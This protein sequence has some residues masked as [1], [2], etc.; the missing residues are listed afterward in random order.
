MA[1]PTSAAKK[2]SIAISAQLAAR[3]AKT[4]RLNWCASGNPRAYQRNEIQIAAI[5]A[6]ASSES[7]NRYR[8]VQ[9]ANLADSS[10]FPD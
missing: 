2:V 3:F 4:S 7:R 5:I 6:D 8:T 9:A 10:T 1:Q